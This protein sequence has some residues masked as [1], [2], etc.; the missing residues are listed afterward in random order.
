MLKAMVSTTVAGEYGRVSLTLSYTLRCENNYYGDNCTMY[1]I[2]QDDDDNG[3]YTCDSETGEIV[4]RDGWKNPDT[5]CTEGNDHYSYQYLRD[6]ACTCDSM[7]VI[8]AV[9]WLCWQQL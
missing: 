4:C 7:H 3:H 6:N 9:T 1:C 8:P 5:N 2:P